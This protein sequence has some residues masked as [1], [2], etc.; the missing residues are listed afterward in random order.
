MNGEKER[1]WEEAVIAYL[2]ILAQHLPKAEENHKS[3][4]SAQPASGPMQMT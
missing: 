3:P 2:Q 4:Q 1:N